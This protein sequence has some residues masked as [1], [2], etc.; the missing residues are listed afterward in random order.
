M[1][2]YL[3]LLS[4]VVLGLS[5]CKKVDFVAEQAAIDEAKIQ[6]YISAN[7]ITV[8]KD[9]SGI[10]YQILKTGTGAY[11]TATSTIQVGYTGKLLNGTTFEA[12]SSAVLP[13]SGTIKGWQVGMLKVNAG[14]VNAGT[15]VPGSGGRILLI[16]P[17]AM[18]YGETGSGKIPANSPLVF[19]IDLI[20]V[21]N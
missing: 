1:K 21:A 5:S 9:P 18:A 16:I 14:T 17:S 3:L 4:V 12:S 20:G 13:L 19:T 10:Y 7:N 8:T 11:P 15:Y 2:K 6:A